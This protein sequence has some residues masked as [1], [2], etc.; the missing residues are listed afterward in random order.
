MMGLLSI[1]WGLILVAF[2]IYMLFDTY[3]FDIGRQYSDPFEIRA[4]FYAMWTATLFVG[5]ITVWI[6]YTKK[7]RGIK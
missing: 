1:I 5:L 7:L 2:S 4:I 6:G 3:E